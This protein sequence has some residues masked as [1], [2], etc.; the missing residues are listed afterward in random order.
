MVARIASIVLLVAVMAVMAP[1]FGQ[2]T[3]PAIATLS[4]DSLYVEAGGDAVDESAIISA[5][6]IAEG[7]GVDLKVAVLAAGNAEDLASTIATG[8][9]GATVL[10]FTPTSYG[11]F[12]DMLSQSRLDAALSDSADELSGPDVA[13]GVTAFAEALD[14]DRDSG[15]ISAGLVVAGIIGLLVVVGVGGRMWEVRTRDARQARRR[16]RRRSEL[17]DGTRKLADRVL[18]LS[19]PVELADDAALS[20][21]YADAT[22]RFDEA[23][24]AIAEAKTMHELDR[25]AERLAQANSLLDEIR[26]GIQAAG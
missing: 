17:T 20:K 7:H 22:A 2:D 1:A 19:D 14:P 8:L 10:V 21:K 11:A 6:G 3:G 24:L 26:T 18:E 25:V 15:G 23:E 5:I 9:D 13:E 4:K 12:S 16:D